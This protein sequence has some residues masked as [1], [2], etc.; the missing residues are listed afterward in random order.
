M[1]D[2]TMHVDT[3]CELVETALAAD[4]DAAWSQAADVSLAR[5]RLPGGTEEALRHAEQVAELIGRVEARRLLA[6]DELE[7]IASERRAL[8]THSRAV[9]SYGMS[10]AYEPIERLLRRMLAL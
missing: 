5:L 9:T 2:T 4:D 3:W 1:N 8:V 7:A 6:R 10:E